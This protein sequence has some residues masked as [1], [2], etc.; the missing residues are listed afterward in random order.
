MPNCFLREIILW[1]ATLAVSPG[2]A[3]DC[4]RNAPNLDLNQGATPSGSVGWGRFLSAPLTRDAPAQVFSQ[5]NRFVALLPLAFAVL[6]GTVPRASGQSTPDYEQPPVNY[7]ATK[8]SDAVAQL[9]QRIELG[10]LAFA[11]SDQEVLRDVLRA[12]RVPV[13]SQLVVFSKTSLQRGRI[14][15]DHPRALYFSDSVYVGWVPGGLIELVAIDPQLGP[16]FYSFDPQAARGA[17]RK[18]V[19]DSDCLRCHGGAFVRDI[20]GVFARSVIPAAS[21]EPLLRH[22]TELVDDETPFEKRWG[23]WYVTGYSGEVNHRGN[24]FGSE[25]GD[26]LVFELSSKRPVEL[27]EFFDTS[28]YPQKTSDVVALLV[29][30]H[31][32][33]V[34]NAVTHAAHHCRKMLEYQRGLQKAMNDPITDEP[35]YDSVKSVFASA[36]QTVVDRLLFRDAAP[37]PAGVTGSDAFRASF[38]Q[39]APRSRAGHALKDLQL[40]DRLFAQRCSYMIYSEMFAAMPAQLKTRIF[41][42]LYTALHDDSPKSRYAY[43]DAD[44]KRRSAEILL[45]THPEVKAHWQAHRDRQATW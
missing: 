29:F 32:M 23:G 34:Q 15:P 22:G 19:R 28:V 3:T 11:G 37:L 44:E 9:Q 18:F 42:R 17:A 5:M 4:S 13:E 30:E 24:A 36:V 38:A 7:S 31:Q 27:S 33:A 12:L 45:E 35:S 16:V 6:A 20:P 21:G 8:P 1:R 10:E 40:R 26:E 2:H 25:A 39:A 43:L 14:R 41:E